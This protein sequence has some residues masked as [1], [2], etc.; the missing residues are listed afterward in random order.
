M[1][2][3]VKTDVCAFSGFKIYPGHGRRFVRVDSKVFIFINRKSEEQ[4]HHKANPRKVAWTVL[5]RRLHKKGKTEGDVVKRRTKR[6]QKFQ[7]AIV[8]ASLEQIK[9]KREQKPDARKAAREAALREIKARKQKKPAAAKPAAPAAT[10]PVAAK[11][12]AGKKQ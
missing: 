6:T 3:V 8:G 12:A 11:P 9:A 7:R 1:S 10:K 2:R 5:Y 4:F